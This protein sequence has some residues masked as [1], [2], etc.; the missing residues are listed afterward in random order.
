MTALRQDAFDLVR[1][2]IPELAGL[3]TVNGTEYEMSY[4]FHES[5]RLDGFRLSK[6]SGEGEVYDIPRNMTHCDC[7]DFAYR[8]PTTGNACKHIR[9]VKWFL[10]Q[11]VSTE[12]TP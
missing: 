4:I 12:T 9:A 10:G 3:L 11:L 1:R 6:L 8:H 7:K 5:G 2:P